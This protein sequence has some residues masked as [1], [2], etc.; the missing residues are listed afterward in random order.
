MPGIDMMVRNL[1]LGPLAETVFYV[2]NI[3]A[4]VLVVKTTASNSHQLLLQP[5][6]LWIWNHTPAVYRQHP[7]PNAYTFYPCGAKQRYLYCTL[8][9]ELT[10][11]IFRR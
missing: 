1:P 2:E 10:Q 11:R 6:R 8:M 4:S 9:I 5:V 7:V 3:A